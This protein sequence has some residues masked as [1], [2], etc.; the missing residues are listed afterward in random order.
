[1]RLKGGQK[2]KRIEIVV[3][4]RGRAL[5]ELDLR[6]QRIADA[7]FRLLPLEER[8]CLWGEEVY[9]DIPLE[10]EDE[11]PIPSAAPG[12]ISYWS[13]GPALCIFFGNTQ[14]ISDVN[15]LG[16]VVEGL[17]IFKEVEAGDKIILNKL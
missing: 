14:P 17:D 5:A 12:D 3:Q 6:N 9:F 10:T 2:L 15:H 11:N 1:V 8:A 13:P 7:L 4:G 16:K